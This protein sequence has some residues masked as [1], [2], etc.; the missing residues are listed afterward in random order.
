MSS[1]IAAKVQPKHEKKPKET[2]TEVEN[3]LP[4]NKKTTNKSSSVVLQS[5]LVQNVMQ[6]LDAISSKL[7]QLALDK[8][9]HSSSSDDQSQNKNG[10]TPSPRHSVDSESTLTSVYPIVE[11]KEQEICKKMFAPVSVLPKPDELKERLLDNLEEPI[12][13]HYAIYAKLEKCVSKDILQKNFSIVEQTGNICPTLTPRAETALLVS[14]VGKGT[15]MM[16]QHVLD[17]F[18]MAIFCTAQ[19]ECTDSD[20]IIDRNAAEPS[21]TQQGSRPDFLF[22]INGQLVFKGEEKR[23]GN[24]RKIALELSDKMIPGCVGK[25][26]SPL[27]YLLGYAT[28]GSRVIFECIH[29]DAKMQECSNIINLEKL[30]DRVTM[31]ITMVNILR[32]SRAL[33]QTN[34]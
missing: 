2:K 14:I 24:V 29:D 11:S 19:T 13:I 7:S 9:G 15:E 18:L 25:P 20:M 6:Q 22:T 8:I 23:R 30:S 10:T 31:I 1:R 28:A 4:E 17:A 16:Q 5:G 33:V 32:I 3:K 26:D 12:P 34:K 27:K 21:A